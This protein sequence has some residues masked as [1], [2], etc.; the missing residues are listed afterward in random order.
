MFNN[1]TARRGG[2]PPENSTNYEENDESWEHVLLLK[3][4]NQR[5]LNDPIK[6]SRALDESSLQNHGQHHTTTNKKR[7][8]IVIKYKN[9]LPESTL[10]EILSTKKIGNIEGSRQLAGKTSATI[11]G[12]I[13][14]VA[15]AVDMDE[16]RK[17]IKPALSRMNIYSSEQEN[18]T[19]KEVI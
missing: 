8:L 9:T 12:V 19:I 10:D 16:V 4:K 3:V 5:D 7:G 13:Y 14:D 11:C 6:T 1:E 18:I 17:R 15:A 2:R